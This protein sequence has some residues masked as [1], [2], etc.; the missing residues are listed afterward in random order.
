[1]KNLSQRYLEEF[2]NFSASYKSQ[3]SER[4][5]DERKMK[6]IIAQ[7]NLD[8]DSL[9]RRLKEIDALIDKMK[10]A[11]V[12]LTSLLADKKAKTNYLQQEKKSLDEIL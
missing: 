5:Q 4:S 2:K 11:N 1:M 9:Q 3:L 8:I 7:H 10:H 12:N 6:S